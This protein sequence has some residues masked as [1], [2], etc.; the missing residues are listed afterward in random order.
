M[1]PQQPSETG[2]VSD[3]TLHMGKLRHRALDSLPTTLELVRGWPVE[4]VA[5]VWVV[6]TLWGPQA[7]ARIP[8]LTIFRMAA[9]EWLAAVEM[10][11]RDPAGGRRGVRLR[12]A[13]WRHTHILTSPGAALLLPFPCSGRVGP[14]RHTPFCG[15]L[16]GVCRGR[17][18]TPPAA[19]VTACG[20]GAAP[21]W[22]LSSASIQQPS[23]QNRCPPL[24]V[25]GGQM[26]LCPQRL[27]PFPSCAWGHL[28]VSPALSRPLFSLF[29]FPAGAPA[30]TAQEPH[31]L[32]PSG[33]G[34]L[35]GASSDSP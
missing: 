35:R 15:G 6:C 18:P 5:E 14:C 12:G 20:P 34:R 3:L 19:T 23:P 7:S 11:S 24:T 31:F 2:P 9:L 27:S 28:A 30:P 22:G 32:H 4:L 17:H 13:C 16:R 21:S 25:Q 29:G 26:V 1:I 33:Q 10:S 8:T